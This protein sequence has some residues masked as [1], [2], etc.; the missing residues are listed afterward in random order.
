M[1]PLLLSYALVGVLAVLLAFWSSAIRRTVLTE[2]LLALCLGILA[3]PVLGLIDLPDR[4]GAALMRE[5]SRA[6]L[7]V[8]LMA[9]ALRFPIG[10]YRAVLRP[11]LVLL[12]AG[13]VGMAVVTAGLS[14]LLLGVPLAVAAPLGSCLT[15]TDP[16]LASSIVSGGPAAGRG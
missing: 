12:S 4:L 5:A 1:D 8:S 2:P 6:L 10:D 13:M 15:P 11:V 3:G 7:A 14:G 16:V 9:V